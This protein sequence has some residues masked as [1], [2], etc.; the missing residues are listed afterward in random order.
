MVAFVGTALAILL[1]N[2]ALMTKRKSEIEREL[3]VVKDK[4]VTDPLTGLKNKSAFTSFE[5]EMN[6]RIKS[7]TAP[8]FALVVCDVNGLKLINDTLGHK[9]GDEYIRYTADCLRVLFGKS[10]IFRIGGDEFAVH[11]C[12][13]DYNDRHTIMEK[14]NKRAV[15][16]I[17]TDEPVISA[18]MS[19]YD[20]EKDMDIHSIFER[21]DS[22]MY[23]RKKE[24][25][26][27]GSV[28][29]R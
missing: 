12:G 20:P 25:G 17:G 5:S 23:E 26:R 16:N 18:G 10:P 11:L 6:K 13:S 19:D 29:R 21:A 28:T 15:N 14:L 8:S 2:Y 9:V 27:M 1:N 24:L 22:L 4:A 3:G 7:G